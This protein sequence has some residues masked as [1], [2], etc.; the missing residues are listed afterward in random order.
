MQNLVNRIIIPTEDFNYLDGDIDSVLNDNCYL[1]YYFEKVC[2]ENNIETC[3]KQ[4]IK[5]NLIIFTKALICEIRSK[6][7][8]NFKIFKKLS[9]FS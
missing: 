8:T 9:L 7:P 5:N 6:L 2:N 1:R 4:I 3:E